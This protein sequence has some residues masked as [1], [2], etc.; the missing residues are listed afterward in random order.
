VFVEVKMIANQGAGSRP[1]LADQV[2]ARIEAAFQKTGEIVTRLNVKVSDGHVV[3]DGN[4]YSVAARRAAEKAA[5]DTPGVELVDNHLR[6]LYR[7]KI[8]LRKKI[9]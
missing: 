4:V 5:H 6:V 7:M 8:I 1:M 2:K 9:V 3:L